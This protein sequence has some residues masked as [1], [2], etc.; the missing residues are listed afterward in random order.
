MQRVLAENNIHRR[1]PTEKPMMSAKQ[2]AARLAFCLQYQEQNWK[3][4]LFTD[5]SY[6][7]T[8]AQRWRRARG[9]L[10][11]AGEAYLPQNLNKR[12]AQGATVIFW[13]AI[14]YGYKGKSRHPSPISSFQVRRYFLIY[15][16]YLEILYYL[17]IQLE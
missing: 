13:G 7:E 10:R 11:Q 17:L 6:F 3:E 14:L 2:K 15:I 16:N 5:E 8:G 4:I 1:K 9:V 12:F